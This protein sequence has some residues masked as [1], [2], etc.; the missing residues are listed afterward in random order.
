MMFFLKLLVSAG[1]VLA[2]DSRNVSLILFKVNSLWKLY[3]KEN[4][5]LII[6]FHFPN[7]IKYHIDIYFFYHA[8]GVNLRNPNPPTVSESA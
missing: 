7:Y 6:S 5:K 3:D 2:N 1:M 8:F 4:H